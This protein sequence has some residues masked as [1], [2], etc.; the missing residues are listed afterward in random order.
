[1]RLICAHGHTHCIRAVVEAQRKVSGEGGP[2]EA[3]GF[4]DLKTRAVELGLMF[5]D[6]R[7][8][9]KEELRKE[10]RRRETEIKSTEFGMSKAELGTLL[11]EVCYF[12]PGQMLFVMSFSAQVA[13]DGH[14]HMVGALL[15][16]GG[17]INVRNACGETPIMVASRWVTSP[18]LPNF[19]IVLSSF[20]AQSR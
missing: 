8:K 13:E 11:L 1:M 15:D 3:L 19:S 16:A 18:I 9:G 6:I 10:I 17:D 5:P 20:R 12:Y 4:L 14:Q 7:G 2:L